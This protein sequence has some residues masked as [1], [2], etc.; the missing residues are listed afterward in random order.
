MTHSVLDQN[1]PLVGQ[2]IG[3]EGYTIA[4]IARCR[5]REGGSAVLM[6]VTYSEAGTAVSVGQ[7]SH[8]G[9]AYSVQA[10]DLDSQARL[11]FQLALLSTDKPNYS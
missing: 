11:K 10:I 6:S 9:Q 3:V 8:C 5:C 2:Q 7:C 4:V 1:V